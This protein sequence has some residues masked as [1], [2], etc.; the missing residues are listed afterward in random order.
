MKTMT[1]TMLVL[2]T[3]TLP[4]LAADPEAGKLAFKKCMACHMVGDNAKNRVGPI[5]SGVVGRQAGTLEGFKYSAAMTEAGTT[6]LIWDEA[7]LNAYLAA[8]KAVVPGTRMAF[9]GIKDEAERAD[10]IAYLATMS[11]D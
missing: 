10:I 5:L 7:T 6:G 8:P 2:A 1:A 4:A 11:T 9:A 3:L